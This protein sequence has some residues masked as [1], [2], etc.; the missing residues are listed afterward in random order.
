MQ[1]CGVYYYLAGKKSFFCSTHDPTPMIMIMKT[2]LLTPTYVR[3]RAR[4]YQGGEKPPWR[5]FK[6][7]NP[8]GGQAARSRGKAFTHQRRLKKG[9]K[10]GYPNPSVTKIPP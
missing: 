10:Q 3:T 6:G 4:G 7:K 2:S 9:L 5:D 8:L 1:F